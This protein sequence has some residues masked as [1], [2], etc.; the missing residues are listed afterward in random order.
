MRGYAANSLTRADFSQFVR[1]PMTDVP[2]SFSLLQIGKPYSRKHLAEI[3]GY[4]SIHAIARGVVT[5]R[6]EKFIILFV[7]EDKQ[8][9]A[10][11]YCNKLS[12]SL[13]EWEGPTDHFGEDRIVNAGQRG[14]EIHLFHR[15]K[16]HSDFIYRGRI[17]VLEYVLEGSKNSRF[18]FSV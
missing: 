7:T 4:S 18:K 3:W 5:P 6:D 16:H 13:L 8:S 15:H 17:S 14:D 9:S 1:Y 10:E 11:P 2:V 12:G